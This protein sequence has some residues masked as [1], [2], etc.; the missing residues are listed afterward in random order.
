M[1]TGVRPF[2]G[3]DRTV[4]DAIQYESHDNHAIEVLAPP[5]ARIVARCLEKDPSRRYPSADTLLADLELA[6]Q[7]GGLEPSTAHSV[8]VPM[9]RGRYPVLGYA[10]LAVGIAS[11]LWMMSMTAEFTGMRRAA[12]T[13]A[14]GV[15]DLY[16]KGRYYL[17]KRDEE[18][19]RK[20]RDYFRQ[21]L[22]ADPTYARAWV[23]WSD[24]LDVL[25]WLSV[26]PPREA[27]A[28]SR[29]AA[30]RALALDSD[31][32]EAH[33][34]LARV[35]FRHDFEFESAA[36]HLRRAIRLNPNHAE[37]RQLHA[38]YLRVR[39]RFDEALEEIETAA[40]LDPL[41][42]MNQ[43]EFG[44]TLYMARRYDEALTHYRQVLET[45]PDFTPAHFFTALVHLQRHE[46]DL[47][48]AALDRATPSSGWEETTTMRAFIHAVTGQQAAA[49]AQL[50][51]LDRRART[52]HVSP[53]YP[54]IIHLGI[55]N[56][57]QALDLLD[58]AFEER[59]WQVPLLPVEPIFEPVRSHPRFIALVE[60]LRR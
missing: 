4:T 26:V 56:Y 21:A 54:A 50:E 42:S 33:V 7:K 48:L 34:A 39:G 10:G 13:D 9:L 22:D 23:G 43:V 25:A 11:L 49:R 29:A 41:S 44:I 16:A 37:A 30:E 36:E 24:T 15:H 38:A 47:A 19:A 51:A 27:Y 20:A 46:H 53:W 2:E 32:P 14:P 12:V 18:S 31:L 35:L 57:D 8:A 40:A 60:R 55:G 52:Q 59:A 58:L 1:L 5:L 45:R 6:N 3:G 28:Q 17:D